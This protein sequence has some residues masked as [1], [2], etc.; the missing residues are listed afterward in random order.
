MNARYIDLGRMG[1]VA[2]W[3][4]QKRIAEIVMHGGDDTLLFVEHDPVMTLGASHK[5][6]NLLLSEDEYTQLGIEVVK[7]DRGG[8]VTYHGPN[9]LVV[10]PI[11]NLRK[12]GKD[13][14][15]WMRGLEEA[16]I[17]A[18][19]H[20]GVKGER[21]SVNTGV[22]VDDKKIAAIG[23]KVRRWVS[24]HG[25]ALNCDNDLSRFDVIVPC[26]ISTHGVT[27]LSEAC[28]R[29]VTIDEAK[30]LIAKAFESVFE[31]S[32]EYVQLLEVLA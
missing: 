32:F 29:K 21:S 14:H 26:G 5:E 28:G 7:T 16:V 1:Y 2:A 31:L 30:P 17:Q 4:V 9:Q 22:W 20:L 6:W 3:D 23:I 12:H 25:I 8:D 15:K 18:I 27:S 24:L 11:F 19:D 10:Y 13:L